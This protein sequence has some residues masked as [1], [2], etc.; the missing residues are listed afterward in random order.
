MANNRNA[1]RNQQAHAAHILD[2]W[3]GLACV[4]S[5]SPRLHCVQVR[6]LF[7]VD[8]R[9][10]AKTIEIRMERGNMKDEK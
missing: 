5:N 8:W 7:K 2:A 10:T 1:A 4:P 3:H 9:A 6:N